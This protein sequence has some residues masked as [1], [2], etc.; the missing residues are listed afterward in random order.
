MQSN[1]RLVDQFD[2]RAQQWELVGWCSRIVR[3]RALNATLERDVSQVLI[4]MV[5]THCALVT[6]TVLYLHFAVPEE[7]IEITAQPIF[8]ILVR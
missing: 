8:T 3:A 2:C 1:S 4:R 6:Y 5:R 7:S